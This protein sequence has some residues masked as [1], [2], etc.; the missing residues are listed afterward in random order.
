MPIVGSR[1]DGRPATLRTRLPPGRNG[2]ATHFS[3]MRVMIFLVVWCALLLA[4]VA[5]WDRRS[6]DP[7]H[8]GFDRMRTDL[9]KAKAASKKGE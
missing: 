9:E 4:V 7:A 8:P 1:S 5:L 2:S 6:V 3:R